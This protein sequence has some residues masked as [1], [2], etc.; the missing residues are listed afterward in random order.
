MIKHYIKDKDN[1][2]A[3]LDNGWMVLKD[4]W[5]DCPLSIQEK[6]SN[7]LMS[8]FFG[9]DPKLVKQNQEELNNANL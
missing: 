3:I 4:T 5:T 2:P 1:I 8:Q 7:D 6:I 9:N